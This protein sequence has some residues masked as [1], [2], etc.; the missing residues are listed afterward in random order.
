[1]KGVL[2]LRFALGLKLRTLLL[3]SPKSRGMSR[4]MCFTK[5][6]S[7]ISSKH[8]ILR[9][10]KCFLTIFCFYCLYTS[11]TANGTAVLDAYVTGGPGIGG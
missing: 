6:R 10:D 2:A 11:I 5:T 1:M 4:T 3:P 9:Y 8:V 7:N